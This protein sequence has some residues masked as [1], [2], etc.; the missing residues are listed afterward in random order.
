MLLNMTGKMT[1]CVIIQ[2]HANWLAHQVLHAAM[3]SSWL[4]WY[5]GMVRGQEEI[6]GFVV[7]NLSHWGPLLGLVFTASSW[8][9]LSK[10]AAGSIF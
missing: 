3:H 5:L 4:T 9:V 2:R 7:A 8:G 1:E 10:Q 6:S